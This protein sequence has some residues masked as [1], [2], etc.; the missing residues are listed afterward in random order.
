MHDLFSEERR[1]YFDDYFAVFIYFLCD[2][3]STFYGK[4]RWFLPSFSYFVCL[5]LLLLTFLKKKQKNRLCALFA[6][7]SRYV[8]TEIIRSSLFSIDLVLTAYA[9]VIAQF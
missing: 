7:N 6:Q 2:G 1:Q 3:N 5:L 9:L 4:F 8:T